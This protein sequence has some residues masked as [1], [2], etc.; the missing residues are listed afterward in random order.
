LNSLLSRTHM[1]S[2]LL[3][4]SIGCVCAQFRVV[5][6]SSPVCSYWLSGLPFGGTYNPITNPSVCNDDG[7]FG[8][9]ISAEFNA[10]CFSNSRTSA[11]AINFFDSTSQCK[12]AYTATVRGSGT[13]CTNTHGQNIIVDCSNAASGT[14]VNSIFGYLCSDT[15]D[16][17]QCLALN[18]SV[19]C[20]SNPNCFWCAAN[21]LCQYQPPINDCSFV[22][23]GNSYYFPNI[24]CGFNNYCNVSDYLHCASFGASQCA[25]HPECLSCSVAGTVLC[26]PSVS[27]PCR[28]TTELYVSSPHTCPQLSLWSSA[29]A[30]T[31][32]VSGL[33][34][35]GATL[36]MAV[37]RV[38][39]E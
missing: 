17:G 36:A 9:P 6:F 16:P 1:N 13:V 34:V 11:W 2:L 33:M 32:T 4:V 14:Y 8:P 38:F 5:E 19:A 37:F 12:G 27:S 30:L 29:H 7:G 25:A 23:N 31:P 39:V 28:L 26:A 3:L 15:V 20:S 21:N 35:L 18:G 22:S 24:G 10:T